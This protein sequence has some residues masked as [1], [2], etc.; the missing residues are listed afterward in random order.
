MSR[1]KKTRQEQVIPSQ[2][3]CS[4]CDRLRKADDLAIVVSPLNRDPNKRFCKDSRC[5][6]PAV[7][8][9]HMRGDA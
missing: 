3:R 9:T 5:E 6:D 2:V 8:R 1:K 7:A 4:G